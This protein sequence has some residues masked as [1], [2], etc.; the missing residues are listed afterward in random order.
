MG[1]QC[2]SGTYLGKLPLYPPRGR[3]LPVAQQT[4]LL[5]LRM[6]LPLAW[7]EWGSGPRREAGA[8]AAAQSLVARAGTPAGAASR[9]SAL[10]PRSPRPPAC[11]AAPNC[12]AEHG[13]A[14]ELP[15]L[16]PSLEAPSPWQSE[17][18]RTPC[19]WEHS[20]RKTSGWD[21]ETTSGST[22]C[23]YN[24]PQRSI[25]ARPPNMMGS[26]PQRGGTHC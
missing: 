5:P 4:P 19:L 6:P 25:L 1:S 8:T 16:R 22:P 12:K 2:L 15:F 9:R 21:L 10:G 24:R 3:P 26:H 14:Q 7:A 11:P 20:L 17:S 23:H 13:L 18:Y